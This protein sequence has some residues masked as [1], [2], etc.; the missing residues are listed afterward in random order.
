MQASYLLDRPGHAACAGCTSEELRSEPFAPAGMSRPWRELLR[1]WCVCMSGI[2]AGTC[3]AAGCA[4]LPLLL[5]CTGCLACAQVLSGPSAAFPQ[6]TCH[7]DYYRLSHWNWI[8]MFCFFSHAMVAIPPPGW[9]NAAH[10][11]GVP[12]SQPASQF[13]TFIAAAAAALSAG[14]H[15]HAGRNI[16]G[17]QPNAVT[18]TTS[19]QYYACCGGEAPAG[20][21]HAANQGLAQGVAA[22][23]VCRLHP[24]SLF[25]C[26]RCW[27]P[28]SQR[29][30]TGP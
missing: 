19:C 6:G 23:V 3:N 12:V 4:W 18:G 7:T 30:M 24:P 29:G 25:A 1:R 2:S 26:C 21:M 8:D 20:L 17:W 10:R 13:H 11:N 22:P 27:A 14:F 28:S 5:H 16:Q 9:I 15:T